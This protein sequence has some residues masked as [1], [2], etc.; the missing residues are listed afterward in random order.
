LARFAAPAPLL[1]LSAAQLRSAVR[2]LAVDRGNKTASLRR[3]IATYKAF[4][5]FLRRAGAI[6]ADPASRLAYPR[7]T[8]STPRPLSA[9]EASELVR[10]AAEQS[11]LWQAVVVTLLEAGIK[12]DELLALHRG[13][14]VLDTVNAE[15]SYLRLR[16]RRDAQRTR[17]RNVPVSATLGAVLRS[18]IEGLAPNVVRLFDL[19][20]R[21]VDYL[22]EV[23]GRR[24]GIRARGKVTPQLLR[25]TFAVRRMSELVLRERAL[26]EAGATQDELLAAE[27]E[28]D[29]QLLRL[30]GL[31]PGSGAARRY[32][33]AVV[34]GDEPEVPAG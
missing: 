13:D 23:S 25:D 4:Y 19:S 22:V 26:A 28:H 15:A 27:A 20:P 18:W 3:K 6:D 12:R 32:R 14:A 17:L 8:D 31:S 30:L 2:W 34:A 5:G 24:A 1:A 9:D 29:A 11:A 21:G 33:G 7:P 16:R 10:A